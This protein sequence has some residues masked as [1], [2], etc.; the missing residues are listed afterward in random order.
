MWFEARGYKEENLGNHVSSAREFVKERVSWK[1]AA[2]QR[3]TQS[4]SRGTSIVSSHYQATTSED[5]AGWKV[6][7]V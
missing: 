3:A 4:E 5:T 2:I 6:L 1:V 7:S